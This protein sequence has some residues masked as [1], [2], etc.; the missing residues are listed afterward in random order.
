MVEFAPIRVCLENMRSDVR[1][2]QAQLE[3]WLHSQQQTAL[4]SLNTA[5]DKALQST[6]THCETVSDPWKRAKAIRWFHNQVITILLEEL[7]ARTLLPIRGSTHVPENKD[8]EQRAQALESLLD[9]Y[10]SVAVVVRQYAL[11]LSEQREAQH[12]KA[13]IQSHSTFHQDIA[14]IRRQAVDGR[15]KK[16]QEGLVEE[17]N[18]S[19]EQYLQSLVKSMP[20]GSVFVAQAQKEVAAAVE[21]V[22]VLS[23]AKNG[24]GNEDLA[25]VQ[26]TL[27]TRSKRQRSSMAAV[28][29]SQSNTQMKQENVE[30]EVKQEVAPVKA[31]ATTTPST[32]STKRKVTGSLKAVKERLKQDLEAKA[33][34]RIKKLR[35]Q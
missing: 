18:N 12:C 27:Q 14:S 33:Q 2:V 23:K 15:P 10:P 9:Q 17:V 5:V 29:T 6:Q 25:A 22:T 4:P 11:H 20:Q 13:Y 7:V 19:G 16:S 31:S 21:E 24:D 35:G 34:E 3:S 1:A 8:I 28:S 26:S 30:A 32:S